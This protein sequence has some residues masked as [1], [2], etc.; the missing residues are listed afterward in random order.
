MS[1]S[2]GYTD[3]AG[4]GGTFDRIKVYFENLEEYGP[5]YGYFP[6]A[7]K[8]ILIVREHNVERAKEYFE[9]INFTIKSGYRYLGGF[10]G[11][12]AEMKEWI[13]EK[14]DEWT[15]GIKAIA[16]VAPQFPQT[17]YAGILKSLQ[18]EWQFVQRVIDEIGGEFSEV[19][20]ALTEVF[21]PALF[22]ETTPTG[23]HLRKIASKS[24]GVKYTQCQA[25]CNEELFDL[26]GLLFIFGQ[27]DH[28]TSDLESFGSQSDTQASSRGSS[29]ELD[30]GCRAHSD[31]INE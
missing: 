31:R 23:S 27:R 12:R 28:E 8:S 11:A 13:G 30:K 3:D 19:K 21:L 15:A 14:A 18:H 25:F 22:G 2:H 10:V 4:A 1:V 24:V 16:K 7:S 9:E 29:I 6:D 17:A 5:K 26:G 20:A